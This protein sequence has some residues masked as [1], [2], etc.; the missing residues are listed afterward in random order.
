MAL[1]PSVRRARPDEARHAISILLEAATWL[2]SRGEPLWLPEEIDSGSVRRDVEA[3]HYVLAFVGD[4][5]AGTARVTPTDE[6]FWPEAAPGEALYVHR[7]AVR[8]RHAGG[9][10]SRAILDF[11]RGE[12]RTAGCQFLRLDTDAFRPRLRG[13]YE[14]HGFVFRDQR[15]VGP[16][17]VARYELRV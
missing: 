9:A 11:A 14:S 3:G 13:V 5:P 1:E 7:L 17:T 15:V 16:H 10:V 8:R 2:E 4:D 12:A 6:L